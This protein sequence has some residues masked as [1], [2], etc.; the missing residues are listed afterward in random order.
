MLLAEKDQGLQKL[1]S[2]IEA[3]ERL[4]PD[5]AATG[6]EKIRQ[7]L[8]T[9]KDDWDSL[10]SSLNDTQRKVETFLHQW[11]SYSESQDQ[12]MRWITETEGNLRADVELKN[13]LPEK[14]VQLQSYRVSG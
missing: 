4:Y 6:R 11:S 3:G 8:R 9:A 2:M 10:F 13:T 7:E 14:R 12:L 1:N 5:T